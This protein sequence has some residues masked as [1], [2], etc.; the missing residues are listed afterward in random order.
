M[1]VRHRPTLRG[2][3]HRPGC[4]S[5]RTSAGVRTL[6]GPGGG[7]LGSPGS[8][9]DG[10]TPGLHPRTGTRRR[11][12]GPSR[13]RSAPAEGTPLW[14]RAQLASTTAAW[15]RR[16]PTG[17][18][19][20]PP[21]RLWPDGGR[22]GRLQP[23]RRRATARQGQPRHAASHEAVP[24]LPGQSFDVLAGRAGSGMP[25]STTGG[26][27]RRGSFRSH[28]VRLAEGM[29]GRHPGVSNEGACSTPR[30]PARPGRGPGRR[31]DSSAISVSKPMD[32]RSA[33]CGGCRGSCA[34]R[35]RGKVPGCHM[36]H[37]GRW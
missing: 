30:A 4:P 12:S 21:P 26:R 29:P 2:A 31:D 19:Y 11:T 20:R 8:S 1:P 28:P 6:G 25:R 18:A 32:D 22:R 14:L 17:P 13:G 7:L 15:S 5:D 34:C 33:G 36:P 37:Q 3:G 23:R 10:M 9:A 16:R 27:G 24:R 35:G